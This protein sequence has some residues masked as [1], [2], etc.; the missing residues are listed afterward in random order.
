MDKKI[1]QHV[2]IIPDGNRRWARKR[3]LAPWLGH[4]AGEKQFEKILKKALEMNVQCLSFWGSSLDNIKKRPKREVVFLLSLFKKHFE[5]IASAPE[6][7]KNKV[8]ISALGRWQEIFPYP[9]KRAILGAIEATKNYNKYFLNFFLAYD[10]RDEMLEAI[11]KIAQLARKKG[12]GIIKEELVKQNLFTAGLPKVDF[13]IRTGGEPHFSA[14]FMMWDIADAQ[15]YFTDK[16]FPDF[17]P[18]EFKKAILE[19]QRRER[20]FGG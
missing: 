13:L 14:G 17:G 18:T 20:K 10:G 3:G 9:V 6:V 12:S 15:L 5:R 1:P 8:K 19:F 2:V 4:E 16:F 11:K 7:H